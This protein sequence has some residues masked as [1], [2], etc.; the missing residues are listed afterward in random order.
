MKAQVIGGP[1]DG[2]V[3]DVDPGV[4]HIEIHQGSKRYVVPVRN[5]RIYWNERR[6]L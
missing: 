4:K 2:K 3:I 1:D 6:E 5:R